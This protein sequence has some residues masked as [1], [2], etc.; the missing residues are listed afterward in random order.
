M[1]PITI[2]LIGLIIPIVTFLYFLI[3]GQRSLPEIRKS[4]RERGLKPK[5]LTFPQKPPISNGLILYKE[6]TR[7]TSLA[8]SPRGEF[9]AFGGFSNQ[10]L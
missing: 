1:D 3:F 10:V 8:V 6:E 9:L 5:E 7:L 4:L 2:A